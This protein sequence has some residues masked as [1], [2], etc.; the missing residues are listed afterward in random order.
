MAARPRGIASCFPP[1]AFRAGSALRGRRTGSRIRAGLGWGLGVLTAGVLAVSGQHEAWAQSGGDPIAGRNFALQACTPCH[2]VLPDQISPP[3]F[4]VA[5]DFHAI[6]NARGMT[7][8]SLHAFLSS[9]HPSMPNLIL[10]PTEQGDVI[11]YILTLRDR[12]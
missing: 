6:A 8:I 10:S 5:P 1:A 7:A 2:V 4:A 9:P 3:R 12:P 11:A